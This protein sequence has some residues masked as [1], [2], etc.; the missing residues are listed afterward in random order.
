M[1]RTSVNCGTTSSSLYTF[2]W[3]PRKKRRQ[4]ETEKI[5]EKIR[6]KKF[7][8]DGNCKPTNPRNSMNSE[9]KNHEEHCT[10]AHDGHTVQI[11]DKEN[12]TSS[13]KEDMLHK[14]KDDSRFHVRNNL[15]ERQWS[16]VFEVLKDKNCQP[17]NL[18][19]AK[20]SLKLEGEI[21]TF[22]T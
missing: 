14:I 19:S 5:F 6:E 15:T 3:N 12:L 11:S 4:R 21:K 8:F 13:Q 16:N 7:Q 10:L 2:N 22:Q 1:N 18:Y 17:R 20:I 9:H